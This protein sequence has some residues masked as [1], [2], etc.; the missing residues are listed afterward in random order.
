MIERFKVCAKCK[1]VKEVYNFSKDKSSKDGLQ[2]ICKK[3]VKKY[4]HSYY[5]KNKDAIS[6]KKKD[7]YAKHKHTPVESK[8][9][10]IVNIKNK[11]DMLIGLAGDK[12]CKCG[13]S[14]K[15]C[16]EFHHVN[17]KTKKFGLHG[18]N[19]INPNND[20]LGE[21]E[22]C[23]LLCSNCHK[24]EHH[25]ISEVNSMGIGLMEKKSNKMS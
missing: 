2:S 22:K 1:S 7:F 20:I 25:M 19:L 15:I 11:R 6:K 9:R 17:P 21:F 23:I 14:D 3:C 24:I 8:K 4:K 10:Y 12:C 18:Y 13:F 16:L 5:R